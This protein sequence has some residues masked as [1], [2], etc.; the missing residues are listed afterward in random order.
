MF[1]EAIIIGLLIGG[2]R[3]GRLTNIIDMNIRGWYLIL[4]SLILSL[5]PVF[6]G[7]LESVSNIQN[8]LLLFSMIIVLVVVLLNLDKKGVWLILIGGLF[9][10]AILLFNG[11]KMPVNLATLEGAG[12]T[13]LFEGITDGSIVSYAASSAEGFMKIFTKFIVVPKPYP[14]PKI[15][16]LGDIIMSLGIVFMI[17]GEMMRPSYHGKGRMIQY[18]YGS[19]FKRR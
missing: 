3:N 18:S 4:I 10:I 19:A 12:L 14:F 17:V 6:L 7:N 5:L 15:M 8:Y 11:F 1:V 16:T 2:F 13:S 9:N